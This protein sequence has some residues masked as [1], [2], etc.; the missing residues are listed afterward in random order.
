M[1]TTA[2]EELAARR[3]QARQHWQE[4]T[5]ADLYVTV[6]TGTCGLAAGTRDTLASIE[7]E[8]KRR[9]LNAVISQV[10]CVGMCSFEPMI[11]LQAKGRARVNYGGAVDE[12]VPEIFASYFENKPLENSV[13]VGEVIPTI[14]RSNGYAVHSLSFLDPQSKERTAFHQKQLRVVLSNCGLIDPETIDDYLAVDGYQAL[15]KA[16]TK[17]TP[18]QVIE[19]VTRSGLRGRGGGGF[20][21]GVKWGLARKTQKWPKYVICNADEGDPGAFM[22]R[23]TLEGD[24]HSLVEGMI[25]AGYAIGAQLGFIYC[26]AEYPLAIRRLEIALEQARELNLL[27]ENILGTDFSFD[28]LVKEGAGA[29]VCGEETALMAS[30]QGERG[31]P[32]PRPPYPAVSGLWAQPSNVNNVKSY[33]YVSRILR[34]GADWFQSL[35]TEGSPGTAVFALTGMVNRTGLIE[36]PMGITLHDIIYQVGG[37]IPLGEKFKAVQTGGPLGGCL[38]EEYLDTPV[39]FDSLRAAGAVMGS[40]G[41]IVADQT[42]CMVEFA[43][44]FLKFACDES[45]GKC[46][47]CRIGSTRMLEI[48]ERITAGK[49]EPE[50]IERIR[51]LAKGMQ[52]GSLCAL[53]QLTPS[54]VLSVL[55]H[56]EDEFWAHISEGRCPAASC[57][58]LVR[59]P[60]VSACPAGVDVPAYLALVAQGR[61]AEALAVHRDANPF[62]MICGRVCPAFCEG[63]CRRGQIDES[64]A[65]RNVKRFM[66]DRYYAEPWTPPRLA[67]PKNIKV[68]I[69]GAGPCGLTAA[70]RLAQQGYQVTVFERMP[71]PGGMMT[72]GIPAYRLP[73]EPLFAE[74]DHI[75]RA[76]VEIR[77]NLELGTDFTIKSLKEDGYQAIVLALGAHRSRNLGIHGENM[78]GV[79]HGVQMLR[80]IALSRIPDMSGKRVVVVGGGDTAMDAARSALR[81]GAKEVTIVYRRTEHEMPAIK[82]EVKEAAEEGIQFHFLVTPVAILG[83]SS[84]TGVRLQRQTLGDFDKSGRRRPVPIPGSEFDMPCDILVPAIG[85][86]TWV[87]DESLTMHRRAT[88]D[89]G[90]AFELEVPG[91][92]AAGD[93]VSG[94]ATVVQ[95]VAHGNQVALTVDHWLQSGELGGVYY[96]PIRHDIPQLFNPEEYA[97]ARRPAPR[98]LSPEERLTRHDFSEVEEVYD[99]QTM[100]EECKR[101]LRCDLEW[102]E[103]IGEPMP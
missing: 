70:L 44:Y 74:I 2:T 4:K 18:E 90:K 40:G 64:I 56:F 86:I 59:A 39:D 91:V 81:V 101:C 87:D 61:Y 88:F 15:E 94:P 85:Q 97:D 14:T 12:N 6:G 76:G 69:V 27:G 99:A 19:E 49:G 9:N 20:P 96:H 33:A 13:V 92:F 45:C 10:G 68:A 26:R 47:P 3:E 82:E 98:I 25:I 62:A 51:Y 22:D 50:D 95:S 43:K 1:I 93:A 53:G 38:P 17:M 103:R 63:V 73:R 24:P 54:P 32:W 89:V 8:L 21:T 29:F 5:N 72:Y 28:I 83:N 65:I 34:M 60:C 100:Q 71:Q 66:A 55:R 31:Q 67:P 7:A 23:S 16:L 42:T 30:I 58:K 80:D 37:G 79:Y 35:G 75:R 11:E 52:K 78:Q 102:L 36:V 41:M 48:L 77:C 57:Q 46:P 84:V